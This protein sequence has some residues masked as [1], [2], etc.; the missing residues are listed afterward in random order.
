MTDVNR[1]A[2]LMSC[3]I[4]DTNAHGLKL[5]HVMARARN[6]QLYPGFM[7]SDIPRINSMFVTTGISNKMDN[8]IPCDYEGIDVNFQGNAKRQLKYVT[9]DQAIEFN[10]GASQHSILKQR[11]KTHQ[12]GEC[13]PHFC[14][15]GSQS[16]RAEGCDKK[17]A[18]VYP[19]C[20][21]PGGHSFKTC[22]TLNIK[23]PKCG[24]Y[25]HRYEDHR[26]YLY[27]ELINIHRSFSIHH[28]GQNWFWD[29]G[30]Q[31]KVL[32][33]LDGISYLITDSVQ[34]PPQNRRA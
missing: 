13:S 3:Q 15:C 33:T 34:T 29:K 12:V 5:E 4:R 28:Y 21:N 25:G 7:V 17:V 11:I 19:F 23:C 30:S 24:Q 9:G 16:H 8:Y 22:P 32:K 18:C 2:F 26:S 31:V 14:P 27:Y 6:G 20:D 1:I 10:V